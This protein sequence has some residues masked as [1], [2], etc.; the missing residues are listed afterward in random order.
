MAK[1]LIFATF[2]SLLGS[3]ALAL[4]QCDRD[5]IIVFDG[6]GSM[7]E[8]GFNDLDE[9]RIMT[10]RRAM[11]RAIPPIAARRNLG[12]LIYGPGGDGMCQG[13]D[14]RFPPRP[15]AAPPL[16]SAVDNLQPAGD[17][18]LTVS[19]LAAANLLAGPGD[20][21]LVT[22]GKE[23]CGGA[24]CALAAELAQRPGLTVHVIGFKVRGDR[25]EWHDQGSNGYRDAN[26]VAACLADRTGGSYI[27]AETAEQL[28]SALHTTLG[29]QVIGSL[30]LPAQTPLR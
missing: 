22:D 12:L 1:N 20:V 11:H 30:S 26:T 6:S 29:C 10:A 16:L 8:M 9:P 19:V 28:V 25:F 3:G 24:P 13:V 23:T 18:P 4:G 17:T 5:A 21:V 7:A 2:L 14:L 27:A 15:D